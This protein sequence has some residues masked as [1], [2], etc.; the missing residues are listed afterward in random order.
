MRAG[1]L[2]HKVTLQ[3]VTETADATGDPQ[4]TWSDV[5]TVWGA[6]DG[7]SAQEFFTA[8]QRQGENTVR[9]RLRYREDVQPKMRLVVGSRTFD[10][11]GAFD[12]DGRRR[13]LTILATERV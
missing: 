10:I 2:R 11:A 5:A 1:L 4:E 3:Q 13:D 12:P 8:R 6:L 7:L 9:F